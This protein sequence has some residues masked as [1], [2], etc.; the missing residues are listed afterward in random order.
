MRTLDLHLARLDTWL[1]T[2]PRCPPWTGHLLAENASVNRRPDGLPALSAPE[3]LRSPAGYSDRFDELVTRGYDWVNL[4]AAGVIGGQLVVAVELPR[5]PGDRPGITSI[6]LSG[7]GHIVL[8]HAGWTL[9]FEP[10][11]G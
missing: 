10:S 5:A 7:P 8:Q 6:N 11:A 4:H 3:P 1:R 2:L 9:A